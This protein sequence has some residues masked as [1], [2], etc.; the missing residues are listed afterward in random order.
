[1]IIGAS[2]AI[3]VGAFAT[4][5]GWDR[6]RALYP[7]VTL[8]IASY[9][10]LFAAMS[11]SASV[12]LEEALAGA[13]FLALAAIGFRKSLWLVVLALAAHGVFDL[14]HGA[15]IDNA[16]VPAWWPD[17]CLA[18]DVTAAAYLAW[19]LKSNRVRASA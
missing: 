4:G 1:M 13:A 6:D 9:Y 18:Y 12:V 7:A 19:L 11:A 14:V 3:A 5:L 15:F 17:F 2:L 16:G 10:A 8:V